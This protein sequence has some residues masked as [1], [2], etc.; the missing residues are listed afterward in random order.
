M[1]VRAASA[2]FIWA[3]LTFH[4]YAVRFALLTR[5][6]SPSF[7]AD[8]SG[9]AHAVRSFELEVRFG[10]TLLHLGFDSD[11]AKHVGA[12]EVLVKILPKFCQNIAFL[13]TFSKNFE[14]VLSQCFSALILLPVC[15]ITCFAPEKPRLF[16]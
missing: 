8:I 4:L 2:L 9:V 5:T 13:G 1:I 14:V 6:L 11:A 10:S 15:K 3:I 16:P 12:F 7:H